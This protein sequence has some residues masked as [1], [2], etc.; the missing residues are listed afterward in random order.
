MS[1]PYSPAPATAPSPPPRAAV[2]GKIKPGAGRY[3]LGALLIAAGV[4][5]AIVLLVV[6]L[7]QASDRVDKFARFRVRP[8]GG[9]Q[10]TLTFAKPGT[11]TVYY[12]YEGKVD[13]TKIS[14]DS[15][16]PSQLTI[17]IKDPSGASVPLTDDN[18]D[19][20]FSF[21]GRAG[22]AIKKV[23]I[24][25]AGEYSFSVTS[26]ATDDFAIAVGKEVL[27][28]IVPW[29]IGAAAAFLVGL[30]LGLALIITTASKRGKV[31]RRRR[32]EQ[33]AAQPYY[34]APAY[35]ATA[36]YPAQYPTPAQWSPPPGP[37]PA[38]SSASPPLS[39][40]E[41]PAGGSPWGP[42]EP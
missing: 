22:R 29:I 30:G 3:V 25:S 20:T 17:D 31:K 36:A 5:T 14:N 2:P 11:Y 24:P 42:P 10:A 1:Y 6:W 15:D 18:N 8:Q 19:V 33:L 40:P 39:P 9:G 4:I 41:P 21:N 38:P 34:G 16:P 27:G 26:S 12:E 32:L 28:T 13:G 7:V 23:K 37:A 35:G